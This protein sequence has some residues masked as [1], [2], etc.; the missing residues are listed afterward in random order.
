[1]AFSDPQSITVDS[2]PISLPRISEERAKSIYQSA[3]GN[4]RLTISHQESKGRIRRM[5]RIDARTVAA[6][7]LTAENEYKSLGVYL[8]MD[9]PE[10]GFSI[11]DIW[12]YVEG[13]KTWLSEANTTKISGSEH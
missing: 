7:P 3:D 11:A 1:M 13:F 6:D 9:E 8:V 10:F 2:T 5:A 4:L 12:D